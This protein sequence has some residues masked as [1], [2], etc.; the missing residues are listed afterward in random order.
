MTSASL[1][2]HISLNVKDLS[3]GAGFL[4]K[5]VWSKACETFR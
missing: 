3:K 4:R 1:K 2:V 5:N